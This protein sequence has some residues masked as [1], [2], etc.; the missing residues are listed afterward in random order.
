MIPVGQHE[1]ERKREQPQ[2]VVVRIRERP[3]DVV[4]GQLAHRTS[5]P[6][7][8]SLR[9]RAHNV[10]QT[11]RRVSPVHPG[12][13]ERHGATT[14]GS[15]HAAKT[16]PSAEQQH[17]A[18][19]CGGQRRVAVQVDRTP[20]R[21]EPGRSAQLEVHV[22]AR[23]EHEHRL[24]RRLA[25]EDDS[26]RRPRAPSADPRS[27]GRRDLCAGGSDRGRARIVR[28]SR[29]RPPCPTASASGSPRRRRRS[30]PYSSPANTTGR[31]GSV[32]DRPTASGI[33]PGAAWVAKRAVSCVSSGCMLP[34]R[35][36][37][38]MPDVKRV[39][40]ATNSAAV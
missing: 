6:P 10:D 8:I 21:R 22:S 39:T 7:P 12:G 19:G 3:A 24:L 27:P 28:P 13:F 25:H 38:G 37:H 16:G 26:L 11:A 9:R 5:S 32:I 34:S 1:I 20:P 4:F 29:A 15:A 18:V 33:V 36:R 30:Q 40:A 17:R 14:P 23:R 31:P 35:T 2:L